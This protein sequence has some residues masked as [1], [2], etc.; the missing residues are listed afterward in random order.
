MTAI[1]APSDVMTIPRTGPEQAVSP[2]AETGNAPRGFRRTHIPRTKIVGTLGPA[3]N[4]ADGIRALVE[5]G[6]DVAR[7]NFS[8]GTHEQHARTIATVRQVSEELGRPVAI[9]GDLQGP[10][11]RIGALPAPREL[12]VGSTV[13]LV[14]EEHATGDEIPITYADLC[15]DVSAGNRVLIN[16]GLFEL[17]VTQVDAPRVWAA[18]VHGG[19]LTSNKGMNLPGIAVSAPSLT[20]KDR[21]DLQFAVEHDLD[22]VALSFVRRAQDIDELR[23]LIPKWMLVVAKIEKDVALENIEE[24]MRA[25]DAVMV[26]RGDLGVEL[27]F[28]EVPIAQKQIIATANRMGRPVITA[29]QMLESMIDNPRPTRAEASDVA[30]AILDGT[31]AVML[32]AE[33]AAGHY[34]RLAVEAMRRIIREIETRPR[35]GSTARQDRRVVSGVNTEEAIAA[36]TVAAVRMLESPLVV[37][38]TKSGF[39][40]RIVASH[41]PSVPILALTDEPRVCR[42]LSLVWGVVPR[43]VPTAR[44]YDHMVAMALRE[45]LDLNLVTKGD[46]VLVTAGVPFDVPGTT[47]LLKVETV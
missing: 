10:R 26:A 22:M 12:E 41:R 8:H 5:A 30:N 25:T 35:P 45:A 28:E 36:A 24:I 44:G 15:H 32:S 13:V 11:I 23:L 37:V 21:A 6:L 39:T 17:V 29:T 42:Q 7:I 38:F 40:A 27:P 47:N 33:T 19:T 1:D 46:R 16:D 34:P 3:S 14:P 18:V 31:D 20:D 2:S 43:L 9:L 4:T